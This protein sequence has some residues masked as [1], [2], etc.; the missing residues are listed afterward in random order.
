MKKMRRL[1]M[2][3]S[4]LLLSLFLLSSVGLS[5]QEYKYEIGGMAGTSFYM[6][7]ANKGSLYKSPN[8]AV[9]AVFRYNKNFRWAY[10]GNFVVGG[11]SGNSETSGNVFPNGSGVEFSRTFIEL[12]GQIEFNFLPYSDQYAYLS[13]S[14][15]SPYIFTG[16][17]LTAATGD[18]MF[19]GVNVPLGLGVKYKIKKR[20]NLGFEFSF[21]KL[22]QDDF[23]VPKK[24]E[25]NLDAPFNIKSSSLKNQDW[26]SLTLITLTWDFGSKED[27]CANIEF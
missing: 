17:G 18:N 2:S 1:R 19:F 10:K 6:G 12:G 16:I 9:G 4:A 26:Y 21:R 27:P 20:L 23:D 11:V 24:H 7:D 5:A 14:K 8:V 22:F 25:F 3:V 15:F 13:T